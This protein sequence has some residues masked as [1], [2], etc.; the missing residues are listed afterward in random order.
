[1]DDVRPPRVPIV[2]PGEV[3][4][5]VSDMTATFA[6][7]VTLAAAQARLAQVGQ[8]LPMDGDP[9]APLGELV[10]FNSTGP[11]RL[12]YGAWRDLLLGVQFHNGRGELISAGGR[13]VKNVAGYDLTKFIV[14]SANV[15]GR[16]AT[17]TT[18]TYLRP[19]GALLARHAP[20]VSIVSRLLATP[21]RPQWA[22]LTPQ[23]LW[24]GYLG[25]ERTLDFYRGALGGSEPIE[26]TERG[27]SDDVAHR[28]S[29]WRTRG[30]VT[31]RAAVPIAGLPQFTGLLP[32]HSWIADAAFGVVLG[33]DVASERMSFLR[34]AA[35]TLGGSMRFIHH[36]PRSGTSHMAA[37][38]LLDCSTNPVERQI[39]E[40]LKLAFDPDG[41]LDP[42]PWHSH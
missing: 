3:Q 39:I 21:L 40:R 31:F 38:S 9:D 35:E 41:T 27:T 5:H 10:A 26:V 33:S 2:S 36:A 30:E 25:D 23:A 15:F 4:L 28:A 17:L 8:W 6:A 34:D 7:D 11:L 14:G 13:T 29:L 37:T 18:R 22:M 32:E 20:D 1:M 19:A 12:G 24:C 42:L 16:I